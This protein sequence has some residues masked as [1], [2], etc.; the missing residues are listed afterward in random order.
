MSPIIR[1]GG[2]E[3]TGPSEWTVYFDLINDPHPQQRY[4]C[5]VRLS[6]VPPGTDEPSFWA[7][8]AYLGSKFIENRQ[9]FDE[10]TG[11]LL[12]PSE[13]AAQRART[14]TRGMD[15]PRVGQVCWRFGSPPYEGD[16]SD[17]AFQAR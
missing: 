1:Y 4:W 6:D 13:E 2:R 7:Y 3:I 12:D 5:K 10:T 8:I 14:P 15:E 9:I 11:E 16:T 17:D